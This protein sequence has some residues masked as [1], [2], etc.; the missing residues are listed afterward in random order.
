[1]SSLPRRLLRR[2]AR[3]PVALVSTLS[4]GL[5]VG[6]DV[7]RFK[8]G[9]IDAGELKARVGEH[10]GSIGG[11][12]LGAS[13]GAAVGSVVPV[14]G[15]IIGGFAGGLLGESKGSKLGRKLAERL[16]LNKVSA[17]QSEG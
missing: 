6:K 14:V 3:H 7:H 10:A 2:A 11:G 5:R 8:K 4:M 13:A 1:M 15:T 9:E 12:V 17:T 16:D